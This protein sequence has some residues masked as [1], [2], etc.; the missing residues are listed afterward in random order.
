MSWRSSG[1]RRAASEKAISAAGD[2]AYYI[3]ID[4]NAM[5]GIEMKLQEHKQLD[6]PYGVTVDALGE[7][8][9]VKRAELQKKGQGERPIV[10]IGD[11]FIETGMPF[12]LRHAGEGFAAFETPP[13]PKVRIVRHE[14]KAFAAILDP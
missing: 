11:R 5:I 4:K 8:A 12:D 1:S 2:G 14:G 10:V 7:L 3:V 9:L 13:P 6:Q